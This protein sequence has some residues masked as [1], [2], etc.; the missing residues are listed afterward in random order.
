[1]KFQEEM[2]KIA[3]ALEAEKGY[4]VIQPVYDCGEKISDEQKLKNIVDAHYKKI[5]V[6]DA[7]YVVNVGGYVGKSVAQEIE[8]AKKLNKQIIYHE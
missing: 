6:S 4:C 3:I 1:M 7:I 5:D 8:Y 2:R